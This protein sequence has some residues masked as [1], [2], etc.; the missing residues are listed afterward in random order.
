MVI[1]NRKCDQDTWAASSVGFTLPRDRRCTSGKRP[2]CRHRSKVILRRITN[3]TSVACLKYEKRPSDAIHRSLPSRRSAV[4]HA[5]QRRDA[6]PPTRFQPA[7]PDTFLPRSALT[8][9]HL[10]A[11]VTLR[12]MSWYYGLDGRPQ[13]PV[14]EAALEQLALSGIIEWT[15]PLWRTGM[16][17]WQPFGEIFQRASVR[18]HECQRQVEPEPAVR[19]RE[20]YIC[21]R[22]KTTFF[23]KVREGLAREE[24]AHLLRI[25]DPVLCE[26]AR[27]IVPVGH[28]CSTIIVK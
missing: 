11:S 14:E 28:Y 12:S 26:A 7:A 8:P 2:A 5:D 3:A 23:Q 15:T 16:S 17:A 6:Q 25:L 1:L 24:A 10:S 27:W 22:C 18:C 19:Y 9:L 13:G 4:D 20:V 21:P